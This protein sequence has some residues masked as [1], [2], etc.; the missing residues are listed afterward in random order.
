MAELD[1]D[2]VRAVI[3]DVDGTLYRQAPLR[4]AMANRLVR[5]HVLHP[6]RGRTTMR[7]LRAY[8][9]A[10]EE[11]R[12]EPAGGDLAGDQVRRAAARC[13]I[14]E[15]ALQAYVGQWMEQAPLDVLARFR[16]P[17]LEEL[18]GEL[19]CAGVGRAVVS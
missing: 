13:G 19:R 9:H 10:Q 3:F 6:R 15:A 1:L 4:R 16:R 18:L 2:R 5:A 14:G 12:A 7:A 17:G 8:R 11:L